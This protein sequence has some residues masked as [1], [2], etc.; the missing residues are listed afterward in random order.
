MRDHPRQSSRAPLAFTLLV[1]S[2][3]LI[4]LVWIEGPGRGRLLAGPITREVSSVPTAPTQNATVRPTPPPP[5]AVHSRWVTQ[6]AIPPLAVGTTTRVTL[7]FRNTGTAAWD[8]GTPSEVRLGVVGEDPTFAQLDMATEWLG[9]TRPA[10]QAEAHVAPGETASFTFRVR[11]TQPGTFHLG[12][13]P[14]I[15]G[16]RWLEDE[17]VYVTVTGIPAVPDTQ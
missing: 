16:V 1:E 14:V 2:A 5:T 7:I 8:R 4:G 15:D 10:A 13:R 9:P 11:A 3:F 12:L 6:T 17:G